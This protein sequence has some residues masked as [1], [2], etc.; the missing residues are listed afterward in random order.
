M[1]FC[2]STFFIVLALP[3]LDSDDRRPEAPIG[4]LAIGNLNSSFLGRA[5][6]IVNHRDATLELND[7]NFF[8]SG[9]PYELFEVRS[10]FR[11][12]SFDNNFGTVEVTF[13]KK[14][15]FF[16]HSSSNRF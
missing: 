12:M 5:T 1:R 7:L 15:R 10:G 3:C 6:A 11:T 2:F 4:A 14:A 9:A 16:N 8:S 13:D